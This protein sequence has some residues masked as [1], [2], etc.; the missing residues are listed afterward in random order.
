MAKR[1][2]II[3]DYVK[4]RTVRD[5]SFVQM[6]EEW[7]TA[8]RKPRIRS[9]SSLHTYDA[10]IKQ[11]KEG[12]PA[13]LLCRAVRYPVLQQFLDHYKGKNSDTVMKMRSLLNDICRY[14]VVEGAME[15]NYAD[16]LKLPLTGT[17]KRKGALT[18]AQAKALLRAAKTFR[19]GVVVQIGYYTGA[20][21]GEILALRWRDVD[22]QTNQIHFHEAVDRKSVV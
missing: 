22:L 8:V 2:R 19:Y 13:S 4:G 6:A 5:V 18:S 17:T 20:R 7:Y 11:V 1:E 9:K 14:A 10:L 3:Q 16:A 12:F 21:I 15:A